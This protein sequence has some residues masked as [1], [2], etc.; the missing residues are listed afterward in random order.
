[1]LGRSKYFVIYLYF[2]ARR[3]FNT[4]F[5]ISPRFTRKEFTMPDLTCP[6]KLAEHFIAFTRFMLRILLKYNC[7]KV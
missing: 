4:V 3:I 7:D 6:N 1:M 2:R 5:Y